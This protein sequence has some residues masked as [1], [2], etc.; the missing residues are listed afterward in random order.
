MPASSSSLRPALV[1]WLYAA[2]I[3]HILAGLT[4]TWAGDSGLLDGYLQVLELSFWGAD[5]VPTA[6]HE[7]QVWWLALF[8]A[9]LQSYSLYMFALVHLGNRLK[10]PAVWGWLIAGIL[11]WAPQD[12]WLSAQQQVWSHVWLD[13]FA[14][15]VLLPPLFWLY[16]HD[17]RKG[18]CATES[19]DQSRG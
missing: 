13:G 11:L 17:C 10:V 19:S 18:N 6:G 8:G 15:L 9:T 14:L 7:Q 3:T 2:A 4:L 16:R 5:A 12:M 1:L